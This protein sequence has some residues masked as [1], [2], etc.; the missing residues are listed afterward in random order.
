MEIDYSVLCRYS[1]SY[2]HVCSQAFFLS[3]FDLSDVEFGRPRCQVHLSTKYKRQWGERLC[4]QRNLHYD[5]CEP[6]RRSAGEVQPTPPSACCRVEMLPHFSS[7]E[8]DFIFFCDA[9][10]SWVNPNDDLRDMFC[11]VKEGNVTIQNESRSNR[12]NDAL[13]HPRPPP[14]PSAPPDPMNELFWTA[15]F[16]RYSCVNFSRCL[17]SDPPRV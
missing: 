3:F 11:K 7:L 14:P 2:L 13:S 4:V 5:Q 1:Y 17:I 15:A 8:Q 12:M 10:A 9:V 16:P 6:G